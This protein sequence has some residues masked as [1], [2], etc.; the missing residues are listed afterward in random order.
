MTA[1]ATTTDT[2]A[3]TTAANTATADAAADH[4]APPDHTVAGLHPT[5]ALYIK[6]AVILAA[7]T[8]VE[9]G[10]SYWH[11][12]GYA[13]APVLLILAATKFAMVAGYFMHLKMDHL[14]LRRLFVTGIVLAAIVYIAVFL[15]FGV[16]QNRIHA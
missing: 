1:D 11:G 8:A 7:I 15:M 10:V 12:L 4:P 6:V 9:V 5:E 2:A 16:F 14:W 13:I 3:D